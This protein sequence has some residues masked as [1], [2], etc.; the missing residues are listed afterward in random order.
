MKNHFIKEWVSQ[1]VLYVSQKKK[2]GHGKMGNILQILKQLYLLS[3]YYTPATNFH[4][5]LQGRWAV[6]SNVTRKEGSAERFF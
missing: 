3:I 4:S 6:T 2:K 1:Y 5:S